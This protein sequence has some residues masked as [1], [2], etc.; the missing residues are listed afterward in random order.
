MVTESAI[1]TLSSLM[2]SRVC[3]KHASNVCTEISAC[4]FKT[5]MQLCAT[6][7]QVAALSHKVM[8]DSQLLREVLHYKKRN[9]YSSA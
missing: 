3:L 6:L 4:K 5:D 9:W 1:S 2:Y 8:S 7:P